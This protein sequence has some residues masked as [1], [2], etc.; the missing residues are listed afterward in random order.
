MP[1]T[2]KNSQQTQVELLVYTWGQNLQKLTRDF[3]NWT[4]SQNVTAQ[5]LVIYCRRYSASLLAQEKAEQAILEE[6]QNNFN[7]DVPSGESS[8]FHA[9]EGPD[10]ITAYINRPFTVSCR[11][12]RVSCNSYEFSWSRGVSCLTK[13]YSPTHAK[14]PL[15]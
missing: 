8:Y 1:K 3:E 11:R 15:T 6:P 9:N 7:L 2:L 13:N 5:L 10:R 12:I 14:S 4:K